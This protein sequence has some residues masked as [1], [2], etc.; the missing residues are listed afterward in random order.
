MKHTL[1]VSTVIANMM[2][3][4]ITLGLAAILIAWTGSTYG[5]FTSGSQIFYAQRGQAMQERFTVENTF[6]NTTGTNRR[7]LIFVRNDGAEQVN[8]V[9]IYVN[10]NNFGTTGSG[11]TCNVPVTIPVAGVCEFNVN[12]QSLNPNPKTGDTLY[13]IV[14]S[15]R[16]NRATY[17]LRVFIPGT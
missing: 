9:A 2:M 5:L 10:G 13:V 14:A 11:G 8:I 17:T 12:F 16:G 3:I 4:T 7:L 15:A 6:F 1:A